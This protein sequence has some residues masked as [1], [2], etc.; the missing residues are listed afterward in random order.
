MIIKGTIVKSIAGHDK[1][2]FFIV[3]ESDEEW[4]YI[5][6]GKDR[7]LSSPKRKNIKHIQKTKTVLNVPKS[8]KECR[9]VISQYNSE[10]KNG[11]NL[12]G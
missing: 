7:K 11:G 8:D 5:A 2:N 6:N 10:R 3:T 4:V 1:N 12:L 9:K